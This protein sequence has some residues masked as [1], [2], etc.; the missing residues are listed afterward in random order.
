MAGLLVSVR[1]ADE[2]RAALAGGATVI[3]VKEPSRGPLGRAAPEVWASVRQIVPT[4]VPVSVALGELPEWRSFDPPDPSIF[5]GLAYRKLGLAGTRTD[6]A[7]EW[8]DL[9]QRWGSGPAWVAVAYT[10]WQRARAPTPDAVLIEA[11]ADRCAGILLDTFDKARPSPINSSLL[12]WMRRA[13][14]SGLFVALA[15][16]LDVASIALLRPLQPD[17]FAVRGAACSQGNRVASI[18]ADRVVLLARA[19]GG[20]EFSQSRAFPVARSG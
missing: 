4:T 7:R 18:N 16:G 10:D 19:A 2:A 5:A 15:G 12:P 9:R 3:D 1:S 6:W 13:Q 14:S 11:I 8:A 17:L 20:D